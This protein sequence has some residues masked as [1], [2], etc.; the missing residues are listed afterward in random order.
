MSPGTPPTHTP[1]SGQGDEEPAK[2]I[3]KEHPGRK[4][5]QERVTFWKVFQEG[6]CADRLSEVRA[7]K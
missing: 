2:E 1:K 5:S 6:R 7:E 3:E 4:E